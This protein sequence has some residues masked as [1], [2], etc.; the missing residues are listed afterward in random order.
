MFDNP[1]FYGILFTTAGLQA[2]IVQYGSLAFHVVAGGLSG[3]MWAISL[4]FGAGSL[5]IQQ[6][7]N[8]IYRICSYFK[9]GYRM[10]KRRSR[11]GHFVTQ[12]IRTHAEMA[13]PPSISDLGPVL[14]A[15]GNN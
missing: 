10:K 7:I 12:K 8:L 2:L 13:H 9:Q 4:G 3:K 14:A 15:H 11:Y 5:L 6:L 1:M